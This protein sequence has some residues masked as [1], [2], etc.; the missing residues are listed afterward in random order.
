MIKKCNNILKYMKTKGHSNPA[1]LLAQV[2]A[3]AA[4][5]FAERIASL[6][7]TPPDSGILSML[8]RAEDISQ[9]DLAERLGIHPSRLVAILDA[10]E[11]RGIVKREANPDDRRQ[12]ALRLTDKGKETLVAIGSVAREHQDA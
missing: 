7:L 6:E 11:A 1:F 8:H 12:Y 2:G 5:K 10:L 9:Q 3:H 4:N